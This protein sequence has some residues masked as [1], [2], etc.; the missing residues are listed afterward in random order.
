MQSKIPE[1]TN[2]LIRELNQQ[3][4]ATVRNFEDFVFS[5]PKAAPAGTPIANT[6]PHQPTKETPNNAR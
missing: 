6:N 5:K 4:E 3:C 2:T 1:T